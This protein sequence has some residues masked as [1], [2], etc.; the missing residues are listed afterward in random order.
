VAK[1][2][3]WFISA[4]L[5]SL[6]LGLV[7]VNFFHPGTAIDLSIADTAGRKRTGGENTGILFA[8]NLRAFVPKSVFESMTSNEILQIVISAFSLAWPA[9][10]LV[11]CQTADSGI[12]NR[13]SCLF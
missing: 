10:Q 9:Q 7:L 3:L 11:I 8:E 12:G 2:M 13:T 6:M 1:A 5:I 4:S